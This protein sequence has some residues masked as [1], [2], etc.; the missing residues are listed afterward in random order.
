[1][2]QKI[3]YSGQYSLLC[4]G[5]L[6]RLYVQQK[7]EETKERHG[8]IRIDVLFLNSTSLSF[9]PLVTLMMKESGINVKVR[10]AAVVLGLASICGSTIADCIDGVCQYCTEDE[11]QK[12][13]CS[14]TGRKMHVICGEAGTWES[15]DV[16]PGDEQIQLIVFEV[17]MAIIGG[18]AFWRLQVRKAKSLSLFDARKRA[19][20]NKRME[21]AS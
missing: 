19:S 21:L 5:H 3:F 13:Y 1:M 4:E 15:C 2:R 9:T 20:R 10:L 7:L 11:M 18:L 12:K 8:K 16:S 17:V 6:S 14:L